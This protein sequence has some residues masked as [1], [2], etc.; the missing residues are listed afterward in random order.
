M[1]LLLASACLAFGL[2]E[3]GGRAILRGALGA[4]HETTVD[5]RLRPNPHRG[6]NEDGIRSTRG[7]S[8]FAGGSYNIVFLGDSFT[9]GVYVPA[10]AAFPSRVEALLNESRRPGAV[11]VA[12]FGWA[13]SSP[14]L[15]LR[16]LR[17]IGARYRPRL[18]VLC[19]DMTDFHDD[20][21]YRLLLEEGELLLSPTRFLLRRLG[22]GGGTAPLFGPPA[23][24]EVLPQDRFF[25]VNQPLEQSLPLLREI[26]DNI[27]A[28][29][30]HAR[31]SL[32]ARFVLVL[33]PRGFQY[34]DRESPRSWER[35]AY[36]AL[37]P[38]V[39][40]PF[41][42]LGQLSRWADFPVISLLDAFRSSGVFPTSFDHDPHWNEQG[43]GVAASALTS[44]LERLAAAGHL[45][46]PPA[47]VP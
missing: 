7:A 11:K 14:L 23:G 28:I 41:R 25:I 44:H 29:A 12:N 46:L 9:Y 45:D 31:D 10:P 24:R 42:W 36:E 27:A 1:G 20:L 3:L 43:H 18:V 17:D 19:V 33:L 39:H 35:E 5:H 2:F 34:S 47:R 30:R 21:K 16:L 32:D 26:E 38:H 22:L 40:E 6:I 15:S 37:G 4:E 13:S 8:D